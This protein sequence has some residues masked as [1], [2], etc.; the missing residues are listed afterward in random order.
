MYSNSF[1][2]GRFLFSSRKTAPR[3][4]LSGPS[5]GTFEIADAI[6]PLFDMHRLEGFGRTPLYTSSCRNSMF[7]PNTRSLPRHYWDRLAFRKRD[8]LP[9]SFHPLS[10]VSSTP[11]YR[12]VPRSDAALSMLCVTFTVCPLLSPDL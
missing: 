3:A 1:V 4:R 7:R 8:R 12:L 5:N 6:T 9:F 2:R 10:Q 11:R